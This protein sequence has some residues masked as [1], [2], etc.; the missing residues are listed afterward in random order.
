MVELKSPNL[1]GY[2]KLRTEG[3]PP[4]GDG[5]SPSGD[6]EY[7][8]DGVRTYEHS[9]SSEDSGV[10]GEVEGGSEVSESSE[11][12][13]IEHDEQGKPIMP[14]IPDIPETHPNY[15]CKMA[16]YEE[17]MAEYYLELAEMD[18]AGADA[19][20][21]IAVAVEAPGG[22]IPV[23]TEGTTKEPTEGGI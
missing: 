1:R 11:E 7:K 23:A 19:E 22:E 10:G 9:E 13:S 20:G 15:K 14:K 16:K 6:G 12:A 2:E 8:A 5:Q 17:K 18:A 4:S 21:D 3:G